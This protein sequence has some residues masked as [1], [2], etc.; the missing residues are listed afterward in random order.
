MKLEESIGMLGSVWNQ[1]KNKDKE[2]GIQKILRGVLI[3]ASFVC[4]F[5][6]STTDIIPILIGVI[7]VIAS[8][9]IKCETS[10]KESMCINILSM[11]I[12]WEI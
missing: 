12:Q 9:N 7:Y 10:K 11:N 2:Y 8:G 6:Y 1:W 3:A 5:E 4:A